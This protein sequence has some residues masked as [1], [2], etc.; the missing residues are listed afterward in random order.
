MA[1]E[2]L[3]GDGQGLLHDV[4]PG[5]EDGSPAVVL[6]FPRIDDGDAASRIG[7]AIA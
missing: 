3:L 5:L 6:R 4:Q 2:I 7:T 1:A